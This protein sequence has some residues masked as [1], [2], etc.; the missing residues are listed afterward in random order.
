MCYLNFFTLSLLVVACGF[1]ESFGQTQ[2]HTDNN[3]DIYENGLGS[4]NTTSESITT[5]MPQVHNNTKSPKK[6]KFHEGMSLNRTLCRLPIDVE[7]VAELIS[8]KMCKKKC[9]GECKTWNSVLSGVLKKLNVTILEDHTCNMYI[10]YDTNARV[11]KI[12]NAFAYTKNIITK[13]TTDGLFAKDNIISIIIPT[14][15]VNDESTLDSDDGEKYRNA[16][17]LFLRGKNIDKTMSMVKYQFDGNMT[18]YHI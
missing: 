16:T 18:K 13:Y 17:S 2:N 15:V 7:L 10:T 12:K 8:E 5:Q 4:V 3:S 1:T 11:P 14:N 6:N 9:G